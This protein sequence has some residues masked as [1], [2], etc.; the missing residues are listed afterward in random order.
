MVIKYKGFTIF[1]NGVVSVN[2]TKDGENHRRPL[3][4][5]DDVSEE[6]KEVKTA[7]NKA[8]TPEV[9]EAYKAHLESAV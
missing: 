7:C 9:V 3:N 2:E 8:W 5:G 4:P 6:V 1:K